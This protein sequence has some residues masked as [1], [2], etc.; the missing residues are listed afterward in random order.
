M[1]FGIFSLSFLALASCN[2]NR[3]A[4]GQNGYCCDSAI[5]LYK[6][7]GREFVCKCY[8]GWQ[9]DFCDVKGK[10]FII[11]DLTNHFRINY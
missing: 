11:R 4:C 1:I 2:A 5:C 3:N 6:N 8:R 9:G 7:S 10:I